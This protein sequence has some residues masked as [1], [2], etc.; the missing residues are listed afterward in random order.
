MLQVALMLPLITILQHSQ[1]FGGHYEALGTRKMA[2]NLEY[3]PRVG[4]TY[5][6]LCPLF[7]K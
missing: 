1:Q 7:Y 2:D 4:Y 6:I 3:L 5:I